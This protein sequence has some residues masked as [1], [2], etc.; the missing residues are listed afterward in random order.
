MEQHKNIIDIRF[1]E[2]Y[3]K[4]LKKEKEEHSN[5]TFTDFCFIWNCK[6]TDYMNKG[7]CA[8]LEDMEETCKE[9]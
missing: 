2:L 1:N 6:L 8:F 4:Y 3:I 9:V 7:N 5:K